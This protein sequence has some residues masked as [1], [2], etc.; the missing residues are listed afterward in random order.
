M[1]KPTYEAFVRERCTVAFS[2]LVEQGVLEDFEITS[3]VA[4]EREENDSCRF[5][6]AI[7]NGLQLPNLL[8]VDFEIPYDAVVEATICMSPP[9]DEI[10][11]RFMGPNAATLGGDDV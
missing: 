4:T 7:L 6:D 11:F 3:V 2:E 8:G 9:S 5:V 10:H 1:D